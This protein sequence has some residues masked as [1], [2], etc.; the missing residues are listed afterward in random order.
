MYYQNWTVAPT[1]SEKSTLE[2]KEVALSKLIGAQFDSISSSWVTAMSESDYVDS[3]LAEELL[4]NNS[5]AIAGA[6]IEEQNHLHNQNMAICDLLGY[7]YNMETGVWTSTISSELTNTIYSADMFQQTALSYPLTI[8]QSPLPVK[9]VSDVLT[10]MHSNSA[11]WF[12]ADN[13]GKIAL[14]DQNVA[15]SYLINAYMDGNGDWTTSLPYNFKID[16][17]DVVRRMIE[18]TD[19]WSYSSSE[20]QSKLHNFNM[21][22]GKL[23]GFFYDDSTGSWFGIGGINYYGS[24]YNEEAKNVQTYLKAL[25]YTDSNGY[26]IDTDGYFGSHSRSAL[27]KFLHANGYLYLTQDSLTSANR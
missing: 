2:D 24:V 17:K 23:L 1:A 8:N 25:G 12:Y 27:D 21:A 6:S 19:A 26:V 22:Y 4:Q 16:C 11:A 3:S 7:Q 10:L 13:S 5:E 15:L 14:Q 18:N 20:I 9:S